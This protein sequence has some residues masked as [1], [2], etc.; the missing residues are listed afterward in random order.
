M[1]G[2]TGLVGTHLLVHLA[3]KYYHIRAIYRNENRIE[4]AKR[5]FQFYHQDYLPL[6]K[7]VEWYPA[8]MTDYFSLED[9]LKGVR[10]V[11]H[12]AAI[13]SFNPGESDKMLAINSEGTANL[14]DA[15]LQN[16]IERVCYVSSV[17]SLGRP[18]EDGLIHE[19]LEWQPDSHRSAYSHSKFRAEMEVWRAAKEGLPVVIVNPSVIIGPVNW[20]RSS[21]K[22]FY[23]VK[24]GMPFYTSGVTGFVDVRDVAKAIVL[25]MESDVVN[26]RF[27]LNS[28]NLPFKDL[29]TM[30]AKSIDKKAPR[31][32]V[33][34]CITEI[35]W[36]IN[37][38]L[39]FI[40]GKAPAITRDTARSAQ[41]K[42]YFS[43]EKFKNKFNFTFISI[44]DSVANAAQWY[45]NKSTP[46][47][48]N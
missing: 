14:M 36:R 20:K 48:K 10:Y 7:K 3:E 2:G 5:I 33:S 46:L 16:K 17:S 27:I 34:K 28:E 6:W 15:C 1:T 29:F 21:G 32:K 45:K 24:K 37:L 26:E 9:A 25:L 40:A 42:S 18:V 41:T 22:L 8:D 39:C 31:I 4:E 11:I 19:E 38:F 35:G 43:N 13:V 23:S 47:R 44:E 30:I 12:A